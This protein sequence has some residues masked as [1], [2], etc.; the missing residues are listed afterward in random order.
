MES[1]NLIRPPPG[2]ESGATS[3]RAR[4]IRL[5]ELGL[6][7]LVERAVRAAPRVLPQGEPVPG[8]SLVADRIGE[9]GAHGRHAVRD[10]RPLV[11]AVSL[12]D[13]DAHTLAT[14]RPQRPR[15]SAGVINT[16][17]D[18][19]FTMTTLQGDSLT[20]LVNNDTHY[21]MRSV[22]NPTLADFAI[23]D[24]VLVIGQN[25]EAETL[26]ARLVI[27]VPENR[28]PGRPAA[29]EIN[30]INGGEISL[31]LLGGQTI[32]VLT[33]EDTIFRVGGNNEATLAD[34]SV[35]DMIAVYGARNEEAGTFLASH[36]MK[37]R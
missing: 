29:G 14:Q 9:V 16:I 12:G 20:I 28:P 10:L 1:V 11:R 23:D 22:E 3:E 4:Q 31:T 21:R 5:V 8:V 34:F 32:T 15:S 17:G 19:S 13:G 24:E 25:G 26:T 7:Q 27:A 18:D 33:D 30:A 6:A 37:R 35:G 36:V 2:C